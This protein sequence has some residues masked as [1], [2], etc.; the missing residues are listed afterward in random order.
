MS[1]VDGIQACVFD[2]YGT[3]FD[4]SSAVARCPGIPDQK[5][6]SLSALWRDKQL[7]YSWLRSLQHRHADFAQ[8]TEEAL[9]FALAATGLVDAARR[10][11]LLDL[12]V[13]LEAYAE[14]PSV[15][16]ALKE[17]GLVTA[18]LSNGTPA[19][20]AAAVEQAGIGPSLDH[21]LSVETVGVF[22]PDPRV[23]A[24]AET[25]LGLKGRQI[26]FISS[27]GWD[28]YG[29]SAYGFRVAWCNRAGQP[30]EN[31]PGAPDAVIRSLAELPALL[32][33]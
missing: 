29:A 14:V 30:E 25:A 31:L 4:L 8:V 18:I 15:L 1:G 10:A 19:M 6:A 24:L 16:A 28:A 9:D 3:L 7:Q 2:A 27:N 12:Y 5:R 13:T 21:V 32:K 20:L 22:K 11:R 33:I 17:R 23:Y 26:C